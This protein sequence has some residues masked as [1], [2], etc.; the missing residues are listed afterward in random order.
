MVEEK[1]PACESAEA[2]LSH[3]LSLW[4]PSRDSVSRHK[5]QCASTC[6]KPFGQ[7]ESHGWPQDPGQSIEKVSH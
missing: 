1:D 3:A 7:A 2:E 4:L 6:L 5:Q